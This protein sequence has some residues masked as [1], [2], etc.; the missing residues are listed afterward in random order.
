MNPNTDYPNEDAPN[1]TDDDAASPESL[2]TYYSLKRK[3]DPKS[4][5][6]LKIII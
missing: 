2:I 3:F 4:M 5:L 1:Y 6:K